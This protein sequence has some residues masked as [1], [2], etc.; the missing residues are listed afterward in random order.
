MCIYI[1]QHHDLNIRTN[2]ERRS[3]RKEWKDFSFWLIRT[4]RKS[5]VA[6]T[7][8]TCWWE[9]NVIFATSVVACCRVTADHRPDRRRRPSDYKTNS[10]STSRCNLLWGFWLF[11]SLSFTRSLFTHSFEHWELVN[12]R[13]VPLTWTVCSSSAC[14]P[15]G[16]AAEPHCQRLTCCESKINSPVMK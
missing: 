8:F 7:H 1:L 13:T 16:G 10:S 9:I 6:S 11:Y 15:A 4:M 12:C 3:F 5:N 14:C 2:N